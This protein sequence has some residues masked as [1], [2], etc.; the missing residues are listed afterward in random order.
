M[1]GFQKRSETA[2]RLYKDSEA[3]ISILINLILQPGTER[4]TVEFCRDELRVLFDATDPA[5]W[6]TYGEELARRKA[7]AKTVNL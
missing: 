7:E 6:V 5:E 3:V 1:T 4:D 2:P